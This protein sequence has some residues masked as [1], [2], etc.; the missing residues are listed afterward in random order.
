MVVYIPFSLDL[1]ERFSRTV[2]ICVG[3]NNIPIVI[4][5]LFLT[6]VDAIFRL[7]IGNST[8]LERLLK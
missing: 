1:T 6:R 5:L 8:V 7:F 4:F 2:L 3:S